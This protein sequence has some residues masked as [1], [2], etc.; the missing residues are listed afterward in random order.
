MKGLDTNILLRYLVQDDEERS[1]AAS[2]YIKKHCT[3][4]QPAFINRIVLCE[5]VWVL[6]TAYSYKREQIAGVLEKILQTSQFEIENTDE[7]WQALSL[8]RK[9]KI[10]FSDAL[11]GACNKKSGCSKTATFD[12]NAGKTSDFELLSTR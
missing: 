10:D 8:Y 6:E 4:E 11:I 1:H 2:L 12:K 3:R 7:A 5:L 9:E